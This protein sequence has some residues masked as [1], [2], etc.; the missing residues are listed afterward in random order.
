MLLIKNQMFGIVNIPEVAPAEGTTAELVKFNAR[1]DQA[2]AIIFPSIQPKF[3][4]IIGDPTDPTVFWGKLQDT[5]QKKSWVNK[6]RLGRRLCNVKLN[7]EIYCWKE[8]HL[9]RNCFA[10]KSTRRFPNSKNEIKA[11]DVVKNCS[12]DDKTIL[13]YSK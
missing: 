8:G 13:L 6:L 3:L 1:E 7:Y 11:N 10:L 9:K 12:S 4:Y 5:F 2:L